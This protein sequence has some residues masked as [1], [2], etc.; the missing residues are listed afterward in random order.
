MGPENKENKTP[1]TNPEV[2]ST[3]K[4][5]EHNQITVYYANV[6]NSLLSKTEEL[7]E[8]VAEFS[9]DVMAL[10]EIKPKNGGIKLLETL[11]IEGYALFTSDF[12]IEDTRGVCIYVK[13]HLCASQ[14]VPNTALEFNDCVWVSI[15]N[16]NC[17]EKVLLG[18]LY[19]SGTPATANKYD[20]ALHE[21][22][23]WAST[24]TTFANTIV[25]GDFNM[26]NII[27]NP[28]P[29]VP[30]PS[31]QNNSATNR[32]QRRN[33][34][35]MFVGCIQDTFFHQL[36]TEGTR[37]RN[38]NLSTLDLLF[39]NEPSAIDQLQYLEPLGA[40]DHVGIKF[41]VSVETNPSCT[42]LKKLAYNKGNYDKLRLMM[43]KNWKEFLPE[44]DVQGAYN[45]FE[46]TLNQAIKECIPVVKIKRKQRTKPL[47]MTPSALKASQVKRQ[48]WAK[49]KQTRHRNDFKSYRK[50][51]DKAAHDLRKARREFEKKLAR[52]LKTNSK[53]FW[54]YVN[55][56]R[57]T[58]SKVNDLIDTNGIFTTDDLEKA[59]VLNAQYAKTFTIE[60]L[61][62]IPEFPEKE[63]LTDPLVSLEIREEDV[64]KLLSG[65]RIDKSPGPDQLHPRILRE[66]ADQISTPLTMIFQWSI[67]Q[68]VVPQQWKLADVVP[69]FKKG[70]R[71]S[72]E[73]YRPISLT[74]VVCKLLERIVGKH[75]L[76]HAKTNKIIPEQQHG[77]LAGRSTSTNLLEAMSTWIEL[78]DHNIP[79]DILYL[80][81]AK[82]FDTVPHKRLVK[83]LE[84]I[85]VKGGLLKWL[86]NFLTGRKQRVIVNSTVSGW[87][88]VLSGVPQGS[89][90][91]PLLFLLFISELPS[92]VNSF[93]SL[94][95]D[96]TKMYGKC[97]NSVLQQ[98]LDNIVSWTQKMQLNFNA[99]KCKV[100][101]LGKENPCLQYTMLNKNNVLCNLESTKLEKD[102]GVH[103]DQELSFS[104]HISKQVNKANRIL[105]ALKH[106][107]KYIN[108]YTFTYL[109]KSLIRPHLEYA[110]VTWSVMTKYNQDLLERVQRRAT[111]I[112]PELKHLTYSQRLQA[113][114]L[115]TLPF[116]RERADVIQMFKFIHGI[117]YFDF[118]TKCEVCLKP[119]FQR[120]LASNTRG[121]PYKLQVQRCQSK[122]KKS[123]FGRVIPV[124]NSLKTD[125]V[126]SK[127]VN[128]FKNNLAQEWN[129]QNKQY[130]Y[131]FS[132]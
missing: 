126:C 91:G 9:F 63:L 1:A 45:V 99:S 131:T 129:H 72:P 128:E 36:V 75:M 42:K 114:K 61:E 44:N 15:G 16:E 87:F 78:L 59:N 14:I 29:I 125:T 85:G 108:K 81:Y 113:L 84:S 41:K 90:L 103:I 110:S 95:A 89:V 49:Y 13:K 76:E 82:A 100:M 33:S 66:V 65:L 18:C 23:L 4:N 60:D 71:S 30:P 56:K 122:K 8:L 92:L 69:I 104:E 64:I 28:G 5:Q 106:T 120:S 127:T 11:N 46:A 62:N 96:D 130:E 39:T 105:G 123:F 98:D 112:V 26:P 12:Q 40:S 121:H 88:D 119:T 118:D 67:S 86:E 93:V 77:F 68:G 48:L 21:N 2:S 55:S 117:D 102:L 34:E 53:S 101:H 24:N 115:P 94:F 25:V 6:D 3:N 32:S 97:T 116:R 83:K 107:F 70:S 35:E 58:K 80:D 43:K 22:L 37:H 111:K 52:N 38:E 31:H 20:K 74:S 17:D 10:N 132:Y 51:R 73:N 109:Y 50:A 47:W 7:N 79:L 124:W 57:K 19:R 54:N 27:W